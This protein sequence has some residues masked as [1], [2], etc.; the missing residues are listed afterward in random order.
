MC[1]YFVS[2]TDSTVSSIG[3]SMAASSVNAGGGV[4][5]AGGALLSCT[6]DRPPG[7]AAWSMGGTH[8]QTLTAP[9]LWQYPGKKKKI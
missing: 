8:N 9:T 7:L 3:G 2:Q 6:D 1:I 4:P 5:A